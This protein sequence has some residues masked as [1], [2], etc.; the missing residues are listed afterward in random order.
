M[1]LLLTEW[2]RTLMI[3]CFAE[4]KFIVNKVI[5]LSLME[6]SICSKLFR[7]LFRNENTRKV[8]QGLIC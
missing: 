7:Y 2:R 6:I 3:I 8:V 5:Q 4:M 1:S